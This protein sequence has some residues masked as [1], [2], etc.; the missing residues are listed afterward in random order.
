M[1]RTLQRLN[2]EIAD[3]PTVTRMHSRSV[4]VEYSDYADL[5][6]VLPVVV[7]DNVSA[8]RLPSS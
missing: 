4:G 2:D 1:S 7:E 5:D 8:Q 3:D 6:P